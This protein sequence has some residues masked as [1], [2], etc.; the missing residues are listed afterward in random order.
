MRIGAKVPNSGPLP[1]QRGIGQMAAALEE[2]GF[3][4]LWVSDHVVMPTTVDSWY[5]FANDGKPDWP[6]D[7][8]YIDAMIAL[9]I[10]AT[11]T[12]RAV[13][14]TAVLVLPLRHPVVLAKEAASIDVLSGGR[15]SLGIG[16]GWL[17]EEFTALNVEFTSRG[18]RFVEWVDLLRSCWTGA[19]EAYEGEFYSLPPGIQCMP[20]PA[21]HVPLLIG[22][23]SATALTRAGTVGDGWL[24][25]QPAEKINPGLLRTG[26]LRIR[27]EAEAAGRDPSRLWTT[28]RIVNSANAV[29]VISRVLPALRDAGVNEIVVDTNWAHGDAPM[30]MYETLSRAA[31]R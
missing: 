13:L 11:A 12:T 20:P 10:M 2:S 1:A 6:S 23:H 9:A 16:A 29:A 17:A 4:S 19:P 31:L 21:H 18:R 24:A 14:G 25:L 15:L 7:T 3:E 27:E 28:L 26:V 8:P 22:G 5:P 30:E